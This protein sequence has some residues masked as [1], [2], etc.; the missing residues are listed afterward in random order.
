MLANFLLW[1]DDKGFAMVLSRDLVGVVQKQLSRYV[2]RSDVKISD[3]SETTVLVGTAGA[4]ADSV[5]ASFPSIRLNDRRFL[6]ALPATVAPGALKGVQLADSA[7]WRWLDIRGGQ[8][9]VTAATQDQFIPQMANLELLGGVS[10]EKGCYTGQEIV[11]RSQHLGKIKRR[12]FLAHVP[13]PARAGDRLYSD[14]L[15]EQTGGTVMNAEPSPEGGYDLLA[16][17][18][19]ESRERSAFHLGSPKGPELRFLPLPYEVA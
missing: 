3:A 17:V 8:P 15:G 6:F 16:V 14:D 13:A 11:A 2:L 5:L 4:R 10:F 12:M 7:V 1:R 9:L 19:A 18:Q